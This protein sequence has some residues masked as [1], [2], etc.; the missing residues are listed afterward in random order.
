[1]QIPSRGTETDANQS[2]YGCRRPEN[3]R[4]RNTSV[5]PLLVTRPDDKVILRGADV[6]HHEEHD[7]KDHADIRRCV[8]APHEI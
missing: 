4:I 6:C 2:R 1:M 8:N 5:Y 3:I 7:T